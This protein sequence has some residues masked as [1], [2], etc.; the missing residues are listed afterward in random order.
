MNEQNIDWLKGVPLDE[1]IAYAF[2]FLGMNEN[3]F[4]KLFNSIPRKDIK[5]ILLKFTFVPY[6]R[7]HTSSDDR[8][9]RPLSLIFFVEGIAPNKNKKIFYRF[10]NFFNKYLDYDQKKLLIFSYQFYLDG[11]YKHTCVNCS[12]SNID[13]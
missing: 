7:E 6:V 13:C 2:D 10:F 3:D 11:Q 1:Y 9:I 8:V 5:W 4:I 12:C